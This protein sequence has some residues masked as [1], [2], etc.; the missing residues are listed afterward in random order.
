MKALLA[1]LV[2]LCFASCANHQRLTLYDTVPRQ[3][4]ETPSVAIILQDR[5][6]LGR[7]LVFPSAGR[8]I[9]NALLADGTLGLY[10]GAS[11][12][13]PYQA[14]AQDW[15]TQ[16]GRGRIYDGKTLAPQTWEFLYHT[17]AERKL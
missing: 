14:A 9:G 17:S 5:P 8:G 11:N 10:Q 3:T 4:Y 6:D 1:M 7:M 15:L 13:F 12:P 16:H 2:C